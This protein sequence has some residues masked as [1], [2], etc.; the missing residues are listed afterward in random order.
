MVALIIF[1]LGTA[2]RVLSTVFRYVCIISISVMVPDTPSTSIKSPALNGRENSRTIPDARLARLSFTARATAAPT[3]A[4][5][6]SRLVTGAP[7][8][9]SAITMA[10]AQMMMLTM[11]RMYFAATSSTGTRERFRTARIGR[12]MTFVRM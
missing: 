2:I 11:R 9:S 12:T 10:S 7:I 1:A 8:L 6:V 5:T 4:T 3:A